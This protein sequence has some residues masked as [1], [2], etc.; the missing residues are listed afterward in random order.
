[1]LTN[2]DCNW[3]KKSLDNFIEIISMQMKAEYTMGAT[4]FGCKKLAK[5]ENLGKAQKKKVK[6]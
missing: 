1:M 4:K 2:V 3:I 6:D 5:M